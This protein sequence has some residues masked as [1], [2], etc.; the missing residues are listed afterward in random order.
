MG[1]AGDDT[2]EGGA[3]ADTFVFDPEDGSGNDTIT[4]F[5]QGE[6]LIDLSAF[7]TISGFSDLTF[8]SDEGVTLDLTALGGGNDMLIG[9]AGD[10]SIAG[11]GG[12]DRLLG[13]AGDDTLDGSSGGDSYWGGE[14]AARFVV[15]PDNSENIL[16]DFRDG[17]DVID[18]TAFTGISGFSFPRSRWRQAPALDVRGRRHRFQTGAAFATAVGVVHRH[19]ARRSTVERHAESRLASGRFPCARVQH[20]IAGRPRGELDGAASIVCGAGYGALPHARHDLPCT[21]DLGESPDARAAAARRRRGPAAWRW[22]GAG[23]G[24]GP[25]RASRGAA[26]GVVAPVTAV[27]S[28]FAACSV[29]WRSRP[30]P[31]PRA[32]RPGCV[33]RWKEQEHGGTS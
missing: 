22:P 32:R 13:R 17:E 26:F 14:G 6:D 25:V 23:C 21:R 5:T 27:A 7:S 4:D 2:L 30:V 11:G 19:R 16:W 3:G 8:T 24:G 12:S 28:L 29:R 31:Q 18:L 15:G 10:D 33:T 1:T 9:A 20:L